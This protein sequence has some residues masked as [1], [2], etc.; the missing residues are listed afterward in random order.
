MHFGR[1]T[2]R[3]GASGDG[4]GARLSADPSLMQL[5]PLMALRAEAASSGLAAHRAPKG[6][7]ARAFLAHGAILQEIARRTGE[8]ETLARAA[9][10]ILN[11]RD[12]AKGDRRITAEALLAHASA[13]SLGATLFGDVD[14]AV[15]AGERLDQ[16]SL[17]PLDAVAQ[18]RLDALRARLLAREAHGARSSTVCKAA[19]AALAAAAKTLDALAKLGKVDDSEAHEACCDRAE[20]LIA[21]GL[22]AKDRRKL[23]LAV[24]ELAALAPDLDPAYRPLTWAR[25]E[26]LR[27]Q[28]LGAIGDIAGDAASIAEASAALATVVDEIPA[29]HSPL[30]AARAGHALGLVLQSLGEACDEDAL[31]DRAIAAFAPALEALD[32]AQLLPLRSIVAHDGAVCLARRAERRGDLLSLERAEAAFRDALKTRSAAA[33]PLSWAV[34]QVALARIY[35]AEAELRGDTG[36]R[37]D[38]AFALAS[39]LEVFAERGLRSLSDMALTALE[40]VKTT[41]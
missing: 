20:L 31:F 19:A 30:D 14:A 17:L 36:E 15:S 33:D 9:S 6:D 11:A 27:G 39:A 4:L 1:D 13:L 37:A 26:T 24:G 5:L 16:A 12:L 10:A 41:I 28:A 8:V 32:A 21:A 7:E 34:T 23:D 3:R 25:A 29:G 38:A 18:A 40:R 22:R 2:G 35:E